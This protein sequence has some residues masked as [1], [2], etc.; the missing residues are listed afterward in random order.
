MG[1]RHK[2]SAKVGNCVVCEYT[3]EALRKARV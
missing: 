2:Y 3:K 1:C